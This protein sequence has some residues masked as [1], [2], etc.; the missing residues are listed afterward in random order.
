MNVDSLGQICEDI[1]S[2]SLFNAVETEDELEFQE[3]LLK[4]ASL[5]RRKNIGYSIRYHRPDRPTFRLRSDQSMRGEPREETIT[6]LD[7][8]RELQL[9]VSELP[10]TV[11]E[12]LCSE[13]RIFGE[14][15]RKEEELNREPELNLLTTRTFRAELY[16]EY[17]R[18][19]RYDTGFVGA[20]IRLTDRGDWKMAARELKH[21]SKTRDVFG[22]LGEHH[23]AGFFR[24]RRETDELPGKIKQRLSNRFPPEAIDLDVFRVPS[25]VEEWHVLQDRFFG[26]EHSKESDPVGNQ[27]N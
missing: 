2:F 24:S 25:D 15:D 1:T 27:A 14:Y 26:P 7:P 8:G 18:C 5:F 23:V 17:Q 19:E 21:L 13:L 11:F 3:V 6:F 10:D 22:Y 4:L 9:R 16:A 12:G 20:V